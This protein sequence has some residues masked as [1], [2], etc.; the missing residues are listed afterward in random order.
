M[1]SF[2]SRK[3]VLSYPNSFRKPDDHN[4]GKVGS[5]VF[6][7]R[8]LLTPAGE[9][10]DSID[11]VLGEL[12]RRSLT[13]PLGQ[14]VHQHIRSLCVVLDPI[15]DLGELASDLVVERLH[16]PRPYGCGRGVKARAPG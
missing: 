14:M 9:R 15:A 6:G 7:P 12:L 11:Q 1:I 13:K 4:R 5:R 2:R 16:R 10:D 3:R 8:L